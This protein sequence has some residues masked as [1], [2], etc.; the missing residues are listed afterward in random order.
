MIQFDFRK[1]I[2][3]ITFYTFRISSFP[4][5]YMQQVSL[6]GNFSVFIAVNIEVVKNLVLGPAFFSL[7]INSVFNSINLASFHANDIKLITFYHIYGLTCSIE[8]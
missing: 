1:T 5:K 6:T 4:S 3:Q 7:Y 8:I 2:L